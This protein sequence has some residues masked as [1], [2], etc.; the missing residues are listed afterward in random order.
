MF[1]IQIEEENKE[2]SLLALNV[3]GNLDSTS[4]LDFYDFIIEKLKQ[5][6]SLLI[7]D[8]SELDSISSAGISVLLRVKNKLDENSS[9]LVLYKLK[10]EVLDLF[11]FLGFHKN[12]LIANNTHELTKVLESLNILR[13]TETSDEVIISNRFGM[14]LEEEES[15]EKEFEEKNYIFEEEI[16]VSQQKQSENKAQKSS[17][18]FTTT[19]SFEEIPFMEELKTEPF[20]NTEKE[21]ENFDFSLPFFSKANENTKEIPESIVEKEFP[22]KERFQ[23]VKVNCGNCGTQMRILKQGIH[24]CPKCK[25]RFALRQSGSISTIEKIS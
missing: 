21:K 3:Q 19:P 20:L 24:L 13:K 9:F 5:N 23:E 6:Y 22:S 16:L 25:A 11:Q 2:K 12:F 7:L 18:P 1:K 14:L 15:E 17:S 8:F 10:Q 4:F